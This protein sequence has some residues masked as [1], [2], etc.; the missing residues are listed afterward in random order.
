MIY[1]MCYIPL[2]NSMYLLWRLFNKRR[3]RWKNHL[4]TG[5]FN[6]QQE[7]D[8]IKNTNLSTS[9][10][11]YLETIKKIA[12]DM[13]HWYRL[14]LFERIYDS[15]S[16]LFSHISIPIRISVPFTVYYKIGFLFRFGNILLAC[17][18]LDL[19]QF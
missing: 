4:E 10:I 18:L 19:K 6:G 2:N 3:R 13:V 17:N 11:C 7:A 15:I 8:L 5:T 16:S 12:N 1:L 14:D 9:F